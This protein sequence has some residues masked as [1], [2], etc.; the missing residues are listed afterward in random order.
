[1]VE[2]ALVVPVVL[3]FT[4]GIVDFGRGIFTYA[5]LADA[6]REGARYAIVHGAL[7]TEPGEV[8]SGPGEPNPPNGDPAGANVVAAA[9]ADAYGLDA[10]AMKVSVCWG[11]PYHPCSVPADCSTATSTATSPVPDTEVTVRVCYPFQVFSAAFLGVAS[12]P[13]SAQATLVVT[14]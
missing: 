6:A 3:L 2:L 4:L 5:V 1:M 13:L 12:V 8:P 14:H 10:T 7:A 11:D 9:K